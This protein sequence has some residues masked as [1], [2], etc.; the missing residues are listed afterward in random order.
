MQGSRILLIDYDDM[1]VPA[2]RGEAGTEA[3]H[4]HFQ[5]P[6]RTSADFGEWRDAFASIVIYLSLRAIAADHSLWREFHLGENLILSKTDY[7]RA[8]QTRIWGRLAQSSDEVVRRL[9]L[10]LQAYCRGPIRDVPTLEEALADQPQPAAALAAAAEQRPPRVD[11]RALGHALGVTPST[12]SRTT[13]HA[14]APAPTA[15][16][17][18][19]TSP[20]PVVDWQILKRIEE[21]ERGARAPKPS[22]APK[23]NDSPKPTQPK[24][25]SA[26]TTRRRTRQSRP[27]APPAPPPEPRPAP[28]L[29]ERWRAL[30]RVLARLARLF[31]GLLMLA[32]TA[33]AVLLVGV[34]LA[35]PWIEANSPGLAGLLRPVIHMVQAWGNTVAPTPGQVIHGAGIQPG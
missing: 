15:K 1:Y 11:Y 22:G 7:H 31:A 9:A 16:P 32:I 35:I 23:P 29:I 27:A 13:G 21:A 6:Q 2:L 34:Y 24:R 10:Q 19:V 4:E 8:G 14:P 12:S 30:D 25:P 33:A 17:P 18:T 3:G 28:G 26:T 20:P 5:H